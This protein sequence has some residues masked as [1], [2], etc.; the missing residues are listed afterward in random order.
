M[1]GFVFTQ[2]CEGTRKRVLT[3]TS[4]C[5]HPDH[6]FSNFQNCRS[7]YLLFKPPSLWDS[8]SSY[9]INYFV[10]TGALC[11]TR[12]FS[13]CG[14]WFYRS[15][16]SCCRTAW[17]PGHAGTAWDQTHVL[18]LVYQPELTKMQNE[19]WND[20]QYF[21][22]NQL[23]SFNIQYGSLHKSKTTSTSV[24]HLYFING[25]C[26]KW[27]P[28]MFYLTFSTLNVFIPSNVFFDRG[29]LCEISNI[30]AETSTEF[31][32]EWPWK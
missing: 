24:Y 5:W 2:P 23:F 26:Y 19:K 32:L 21:D 18:Y 17:A 8:F 6:G 4:L 16:F 28:R 14:A 12:A 1:K 22:W 31:C 25:L 20:S 11:C 27:T 7:K 15:G 29:N 13:G 30:L 9:L 10:C 3:R